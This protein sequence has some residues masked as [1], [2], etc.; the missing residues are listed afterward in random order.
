[1]HDLSSLELSDLY[2]LLAAYTSKS[3]KGL[4]HKKLTIDSLRSKEMIK[5]L[6]REIQIRDLK[7]DVERDGF[8]NG[9]ASKVV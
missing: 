4:R 6:H 7:A 3:S 9:Q 8:I 5:K 2:D 1:M